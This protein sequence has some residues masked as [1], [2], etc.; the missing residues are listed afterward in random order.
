MRPVRDFLKARLWTIFTCLFI[1]VGVM[2]LWLITPSTILFRA[3]EWKYDPK[4]GVIEFTRDINSDR[5][6]VVRWSHIVYTA[7][8]SCSSGGIRPFD[9]RVKV[10]II[11]VDPALKECLDDPK[12][13]AVLAWSPLLWGIIPMRPSTMTLPTGAS[14]PDISG[15]SP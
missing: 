1:S 7:T 10:D 4:T 14:I 12:H 5:E 6:V 3:I 9:A 15:T 8:K 13:V 11:K 2:T